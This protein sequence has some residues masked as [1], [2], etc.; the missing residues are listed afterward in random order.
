LSANI[1]LTP[2]KALIRSVLTY[3]CPAWDFAADTHLLELQRLQNKVLR[4]IGNFP[5]RTPVRE[6]HKAFCI[7]YVYDYM[8]KLSR[9]QAPSPVVASPPFHLRSET[10]PVS[11]TLYS[12]RMPDDGHSPEGILSAIHRRWNPFISNRKCGLTGTEIPLADKGLEFET[13]EEHRGTHIS[14]LELNRGF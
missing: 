7:P 9:Q 8:T 11:K 12:L 2:H 3:A 1:K 6:L 13:S 4:S 5:R 14:I 10:D